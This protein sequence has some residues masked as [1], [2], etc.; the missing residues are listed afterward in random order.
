MLGTIMI[1]AGLVLIA[2]SLVT[3]YLFAFGRCDIG[4]ATGCE[5][6]SARLIS[7]LMISDIGIFFW[8]AWVIGVF[9]IWGGLRLRPSN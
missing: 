9:L 5:A 6:G 3:G 2:G 8:L 7:D 1:V 4:A